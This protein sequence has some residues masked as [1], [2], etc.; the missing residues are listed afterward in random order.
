MF[1]A[2]RNMIDTDGERDGGKV[3]NQ[4]RYLFRVKSGAIE[5]HV[6]QNVQ[7]VDIG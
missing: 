3:H 6:Y 7:V 1:P 5:V 2:F 4:S